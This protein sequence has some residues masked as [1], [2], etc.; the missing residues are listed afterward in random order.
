[1]SGHAIVSGC[2]VHVTGVLRRRG[3]VKVVGCAPGQVSVES[4]YSAARLLEEAVPASEVTVIHG[5]AAR[6]RSNLLMPH[7]GWRMGTLVH[8][9]F[10]L[11]HFHDLL[12]RERAGTGALPDTSTGTC[13]L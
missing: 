6:T 3:I 13:P 1:M 5:F 12:D 2:F 11:P 10:E 8:N 4:S 9:A 7:T